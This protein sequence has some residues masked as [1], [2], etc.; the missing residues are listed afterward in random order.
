MKKRLRPLI[1]LILLALA[2]SPARPHCQIP[3]GIYNDPARFTMLREHITTMEKS[4]AAILKLSASDEPD[5]NQLARW[6]ANKDMHADAFTDIATAYF[7]AQRIKPADPLDEAATQKYLRE[8]PLLH[9][10][11]VYAMKVKQ[12]TAIEHCAK[13]RTLVD[14]FEMSYLG[15]AETA[16]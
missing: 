10:M 14:M 2:T 13:L 9:Q 8:L 4:V 11:V 12:T 6:V 16:P 7:M 15:K 3:C 1:A 5:Q